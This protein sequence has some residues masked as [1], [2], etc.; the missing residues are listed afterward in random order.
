M[1]DKKSRINLAS[2]RYV[3]TWQINH[4][5]DFG[6]WVAFTKEELIESLSDL[7]DSDGIIKAIQEKKLANKR[8]QYKILKPAWFDDA[9]ESA[10]KKWEEYKNTDNLEML[11]WL[12]DNVSWNANHTMNILKLNKTFCKDISWTGKIGHWKDAKKLAKSRWYTLPTDYNDCDPDEVK[13]DSDWYKMINIFSN[14]NWDTTQG[15]ELFSDMAWC[16]DRNNRYWTATAYKYEDWHV[17]KDKNWY[18][19]T[20]RCRKL[21]KGNCERR[22]SYTYHSRLVCGRKDMK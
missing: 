1:T 10:K 16:N 20:V 7:P 17:S 9:P 4:F 12:H 14:G 6:H 5:P 21:G 13:H 3:A 2:D 11:Q 8:E 18:I 15:M 19:S 22:W